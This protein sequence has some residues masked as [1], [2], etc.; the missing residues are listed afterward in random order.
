MTGFFTCLSTAM[1]TPFYD[2]GGVNYEAFKKL[3][4]LQIAG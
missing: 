4:D 2:N 3:I 1:I